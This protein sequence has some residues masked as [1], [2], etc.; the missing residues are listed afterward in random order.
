MT[1]PY[2]RR[3][4]PNIP[5]KARCKKCGVRYAQSGGWCRRCAREE[6][7]DTRNTV[8]RDRDRLAKLR[9]RDQA[10]L[11]ALFAQADAVDPGPPAPTRTVT[12]AGVDYEVVF[13]GAVGK[14]RYD[15]T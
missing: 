8:E 2:T 5:P 4:I 3:P 9:A 13:D 6:G 15:G 10:E 1:R 12:I 11:D 14:C 7:V